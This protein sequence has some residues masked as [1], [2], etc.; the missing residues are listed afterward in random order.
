MTWPLPNPPFHATCPSPP[1]VRQR[2]GLGHGSN[3][4]HSCIIVFPTIPMKVFQRQRK[5]RKR[6]E[7]YNWPMAVASQP[8]YYYSMRN[9]IERDLY[10]PLTINQTFH[11]LPT[12]HLTTY[13][14]AL[15]ISYL[16][17]HISHSFSSHLHYPSLPFH[18]LFYFY[19]PFGIG[20][21]GL[22]GMG[23]MAWW[24]KI[25]CLVLR[26]GGKRTI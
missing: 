21:E 13:M 18:I 2:T 16:F 24:K 10:I 22:M 12:T 19:L 26:G 8:V 25:R 15:P 9:S 4:N 5:K 23:D 3:E 14:H 17:S 1:S 7:T 6:N 11:S 20:L